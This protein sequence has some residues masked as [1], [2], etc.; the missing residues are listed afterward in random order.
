MSTPEPGVNQTEN[1][2][3]KDLQGFLVTYGRMTGVAAALAM[4]MVFAFGA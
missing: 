2:N 1:Q 4:S 3:K